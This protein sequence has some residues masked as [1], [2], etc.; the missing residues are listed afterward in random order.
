MVQEGKGKERERSLEL[1]SCNTTKLPL[2][3]AAARKSQERSKTMPLKHAVLPAM[4]R[5]LLLPAAPWRSELLPTQ[6][7]FGLSSRKAG[8]EEAKLMPHLSYLC[9]NRST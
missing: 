4:F 5:G 3:S 9:S 1:L 7:S 6:S 8:N 2:S